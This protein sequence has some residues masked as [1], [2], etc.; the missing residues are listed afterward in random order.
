MTDFEISFSDEEISAFMNRIEIE[1]SDLS[2][3]FLQSIV[4]GIFEHIP[5]QNISMLT[6]QWIRP[7]K[8]MIKADMLSGMGGLCTVRNPFLHEFLRALGFEVRFVSSTMKEPNC[9]ISLIVKIDDDNWWIDVGNGFPY[10]EPIKLGDDSVKSNWFMSYKLVYNDQRY[11]VYHRLN[12]K[13]WELNHHFSPKG[14]EYSTFD[15]MHELHYSVPGWG[16][17]LTGLRVNRFWKNGGVMIRD[18]RASSPNGEST[19]DSVIK[20]ESWLKRWFL[21]SGFTDCVELDKADKIWKR[22]QKVS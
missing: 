2:D 16:P 7:S 21:K 11:H 14:V 15:R 12:G 10:I 13:E 22:E 8:E 1:K 17:F 19:L 3:E 5:F 4:S 20:L 6:N 9:H 18:E